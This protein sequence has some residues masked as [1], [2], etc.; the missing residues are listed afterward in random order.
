LDRLHRRL[1]TA[2]SLT[3]L[4]AFAGGAGFEPIASLAAGVVLLAVLIHPPGQVA[5]ER[6]ERLLGPLAVLL[7]IRVLA[8]LF[9]LG[10]DVV[11]PVVD[12]LLLLL[13]GETLRPPDATNEVRIYALSFALLLAA[14]A[15]RPGVVFAAAFVAYVM[16]A[17]LT[18]PV[19]IVRR[20]ATQYGVRHPRVGGRFV[21]ASLALS[22][23]TL[24]SSVVVFLI[25]PRASEAGPGRGEVLAR[26]VAGFSDQV[27]IGEHGSSI[28]ANP[29][30]VLRVEFPEGRPPNL[31]GLHWR[32]RSYDRF[33][34]VRW[35][36]SSGIRPSAAP[37][38]WYE[39][40]WGGPL[41]RQD[42]YAAP[43]D[44]RVL[45]ALH[46]LVEIDPRPGIQPM[47][48]NVGDYSY[49]GGGSPAYTATSVYGRP[50]ADSLRAAET[51]FMPDRERYLQLPRL[52][53]RIH[54]LADSL[55]RD[56]ET[57]YDRVQAIED[58]LTG[59]FGYTRDLP[60][61]ARQATLDHFLFERRA[62]HCEYFSTAMVVLLRSVGI[63]ARNVNGF[64]GGRWN[65]LGPYLAV[66][67]N[68]AHSWVEVWFPGYGWVTFDP[69]PGGS[70]SGAEASG[71][72]WPG[73]F[74]LDG[75]QHRW[76]K[77]V[78]DYSLTE[79]T[80]ALRRLSRLLDASR[81]PAP[82]ARES[83]PG[84]GG[85]PWLWITLTLAAGLWALMRAGR[86]GRLGIRRPESL[87]YLKLVRAARRAGAIDE[88][89][90]TPLGLVHE[91][92]RHTPGTAEPAARLV[93]LYLEA[94]FSPRALESDARREMVA[95][96]GG[97]RRALR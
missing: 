77:W 63:H 17:S 32:G 18:V 64:L 80:G 14:T 40:R 31:L 66:T 46:P 41:I 7:L 70:G 68:E 92:A 8:H 23:V 93:R 74:L 69:T 3:A 48:D 89:Q 96:L 65:D 24:A 30:V 13:C 82:S 54:A 10:G 91:L 22:L 60:V 19:G 43:L 79:Q 5:G 15:Y 97:V 42:I 71:W 21:F 45:F 56:L 6:F 1:A 90:V 33:D 35:T 28:Y 81:A 34:G 9:V 4:L 25:F 58:W 29:E 37:T 85:A 88:R 57:R 62:G 73:R 26:S 11:I 59:T 61:T 50:S 44:V 51:G 86:I 53:D 76:G 20:K 47:F 78:L 16:L 67:Q 39:R 94:R 36:R 75:L 72:L 38:N 95:A 84:S 12:L 2:L 55:T 49:W 27:S 87:V 52:P 83:S